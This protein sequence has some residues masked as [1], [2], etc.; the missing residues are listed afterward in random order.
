MNR[1]GAYRLCQIAAEELGVPF[2]DVEMSNAD[3]DLTTFC[4]GAYASRLTYIS[5]NAVKNAATNMKQQL[6][7]QAAEMLE[8]N[9]AD[10]TFREGKIF[11]KGAEGKSSTVSDVAR[12]RLSATTAPPSSAPAASTPIRYCRI[13][14]AS[15]TSPALITTAPRP[16][17]CTSIPKPDR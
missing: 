12:A 10:L 6:L 1:P 11:V 2:E 8:A 15:A 16:R 14:P 4:Q 17:K 9:A 3:T 13:A 5:G 7:E